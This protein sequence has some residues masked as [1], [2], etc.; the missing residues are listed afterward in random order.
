MDILL[1]GAGHGTART[2]ANYANAGSKAAAHRTPDKAD[3]SGFTLDI[4]GTVMD[5]SVY[6]DHGRSVEDVILE[7]GQEDL[8]TR[9]DYMAV[10]SNSMSDEDFAKMQKEGFHPGSTDVETVVSIIDHIK[11][12]LVK[13]GTEV[14]GYTDTISEDVLRDITGSE[15]FAQELKKQFAEHDVPATEENVAAVM[16]AWKLMNETPAVSEGSE[17]YMVENSLSPTPENLYTA[18]YCASA[19]ESR[20]SSGYYAAGTVAGYYAKKPESVDFEQIMSQITKVIEEAGYPADEENLTDAKWLVENGIPLTTDTFSLLKDIKELQLPL[21]AED[22]LRKAAGA[23]A[24]GTKP[25]KMDLSRSETIYEQAVRV[26]DQVDCLQDEAADIITARDLPFTLRN[27][28]AA[29]QE[30]LKDSGK[31]SD[32]AEAPADLRGRRILEEIRLSMTVEA[33]IRLLRR[34]Y[35]IETASLEDLVVKLKEA[36]TSCA[37]ALTGETDSAVAAS[38]KSLFGETLE[39]LRGIKTSPAAI[40]TEVSSDDTLREI[41]AAGKARSADYEKAGLKYEELMTAPR[42]D[43]GDSITRAFRNVDDIL[44]DLGM[45]LTDENR[46]A[47]RILGY[48]QKEITRENLDQIRQMDG[49]LTD[50]LKELKPGKVLQMIREGVNPLTMPIEELSR[51][52]KEQ[53]TPAEEIESYSKFLYKLEKQKGISEEERSAYIG[54]YR[55]IHQIEKTDDAAVGAVWQSGVGFTL[56]N[57]LSAVRSSKHRHM[58]YSV[59][60]NFG[61]ISAKD[62]G[63]ESITSQIAKGF[64]MTQTVTGR[65]LQEMLEQAGSESADEEF[66]RMAGQQARAA[67]KAEESVVRGLMDYDQ[68]VTADYLLLAAN[69]LKNPREI[70]KQLGSLKG[71]EEESRRQEQDVDSLSQLP[72]DLGETVLSSLE[73][74][75]QAVSGYQELCKTIQSMITEVSYEENRQALDVRTMSTL[76]KQMSFLSSMAREENYEVPAKIG[77]GFTS[78]NLKIIHNSEQESKAAIT[79]ETQELGKVAAE[80]KMTQQGLTGLCIC[81]KEEGTGLLQS[82]KELLTGRLSQEQISAGEIYFAT[83]QTLNLTEFSLKQS[84]ERQKG[85]DINTGTLYKAAKAFI[86]YVQ[87]TSVK[88]GNT[89]YED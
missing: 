66:E 13:G 72:E 4:S 42:R 32:Q 35:Q 69:M 81:S 54:I 16:D 44:S 85:A 29:A 59:D 21:T 55:L 37:K 73:D 19:Q 82:T 60:D 23:I 51:Y 18:G 71:N 61:G 65:Q 20:Q 27:L 58:D 28:F 80:F 79:L 30:W 24:E 50:T 84:H 26:K 62:V 86:G 10:M 56:E 83:S 46:R 2:Q 7:A 33:N 89:A 47:V 52:L 8:K 22:F 75:E 9:R 12:A 40:L 38:K 48:N 17:K 88:K 64:D 70:W 36:E 76:Y 77:D 11:A 1:D 39:I 68:P 25:S 43:M 74:R 3:A 87:E 41:Y 31:T 53:E 45:E 78:I 63:I 57:L 49:L 15:A 14:V 6:A 34:G 5:N 67:V